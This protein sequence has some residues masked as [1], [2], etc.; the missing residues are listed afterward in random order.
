MS[1]AVIPFYVLQ[2]AVFTRERCN[3]AYG[4]PEYVLSKFVTSLPGIAALALIASALIVFPVRLHGFGI[5]FMILFFSLL[6]AEAFMALMAAL[7][8]HY[9]VG[10]ALAAGVFGFFMLCE[11]FFIVK[12]KIPG[13]LIWGYYLAPHTYTFRMFMHNEFDSAGEFNS[14]VF[15]SGTS[16]LEFY[17]MT[18]VNI[19]YDTLILILF[20]VGLQTFFGSALYFLHTGR[21]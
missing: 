18:N 7:V 20:A 6:W 3:G 21:R 13:Y 11:G 8:P 12:S 4:V 2:R 10:I 16:V 1:V 19:L 9:I 5:Y 17:D 15:P 14:R